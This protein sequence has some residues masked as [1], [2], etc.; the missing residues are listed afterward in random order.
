MW[1]TNSKY[2]SLTVTGSYFVVRGLALIPVVCDCGKRLDIR[3]SDLGKR[4]D[5]GCG[6]STKPL[7]NRQEEPTPKEEPT[8]K[9]EEPHVKPRRT[10][11]N[12]FSSE[13]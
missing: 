7:L 9:E 3:P 5:C 2:G 4:V 12:R 1:E 8:S 11:V 6:V 10:R 13:D